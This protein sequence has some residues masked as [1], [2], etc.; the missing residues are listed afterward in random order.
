MPDIEPERSRLI[1][2]VLEGKG[3]SSPAE[4]RAAFD[5]TGPESASTALVRKIAKNARAVTE[6]DVAAVRNSGVG[7]DRIF[8]I[9]ICAALGEATRQ[10]EAAM[11]AFERIGT[12]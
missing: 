6:S 10:Y 5:N 11:A 8:E 2:R 1:A 3:V 7:E 9:V 4:R 12:A